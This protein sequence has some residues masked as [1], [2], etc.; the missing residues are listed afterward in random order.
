MEY[1]ETIL[2]PNLEQVDMR[3]TSQPVYDREIELGDL[4]I[5]PRTGAEHY[6]VRYPPGLRALPHRHTAAHT[7]VVLEGRL[8]VN[9]RVLGPGAYCHLPGGQPMLH[10]PADQDPCLFLIMFDGP[11]DVEPLGDDWQSP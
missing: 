10:G 8:K 7:I 2:F 11:F 4:F 6:V 1:G 9:D 5:D 3:P